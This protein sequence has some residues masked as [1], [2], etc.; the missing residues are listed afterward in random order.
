MIPFVT[1]TAWVILALGPNRRVTHTSQ[2]QSAQSIVLIVPTS[3]PPTP[4]SQPT[5]PPHPSPSLLSLP[6]NYPTVSLPKSAFLFTVTP[7]TKHNSRCHLAI[8]HLT[9]CQLSRRQIR[10]SPPLGSSP[11]TGH[12]LV[13]LQTRPR[14][15]KQTCRTSYWFG[16]GGWGCGRRS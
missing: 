2:V 13:P 12:D 5:H 9:L 8:N 6:V 10:L 7:S 1:Y 16:G 3:L 11:P 4:P 15:S 14:Q